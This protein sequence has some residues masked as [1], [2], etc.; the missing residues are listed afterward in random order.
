MPNNPDYGLNQRKEAILQ[1]SPL[2]RALLD[3]LVQSDPE[4]WAKIVNSEFAKVNTELTKTL[5]KNHELVGFIP[6]MAMQSTFHVFDPSISIDGRNGTICILAG[7][8]YEIGD[9]EN[10]GNFFTDIVLQLSY[11]GVLNPDPDKQKIGINCLYTAIF[12]GAQWKQ[13][14]EEDV[15]SEFV[16][17]IHNLNLDNKRD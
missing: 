5:G 16:D 4:M 6:L 12:I 2:L 10:I 9:T 8:G 3:P 17:F 7:V 1:K 15:P 13:H 11:A 14:I